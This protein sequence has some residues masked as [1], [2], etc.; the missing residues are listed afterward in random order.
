MLVIKRD[1]QCVYCHC[2]FS[3]KN[4][5]TSAS[6]EHV[7]NDINITTPE[8]IVRCCVSCNASKSTKSLKVWLKS[9]YCLD[10]NITEETVAD[11]I[12]DHI[13]KYCAAE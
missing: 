1:K 11:I 8:N 3:S 7:I 4:R 2:K 5:K 6:W 12:K 10:K 13:R 9:K